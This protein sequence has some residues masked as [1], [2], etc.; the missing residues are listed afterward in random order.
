M[1]AF[2]ILI[3]WGIA[4]FSLSFLTHTLR[5]QL[6]PQAS[7]GRRHGK[8]S[9]IMSRSLMP[10]CSDS[11]FSAYQ[12]RVGRGCAVCA[13]CLYSSLKSR[14]GPP[15]PAESCGCRMWKGARCKQKSET[16]GCEM[17]TQTLAQ[18]HV[19]FCLIGT[20][21]RAVKALLDFLFVFLLC[22]QWTGKFLRCSGWAKMWTFFISGLASQTLGRVLEQIWWEGP[23]G[24]GA[25]QHLRT[26]V[27]SPG[28]MLKTATCKWIAWPLHMSCGR[29]PK[30][31]RKQN[32]SFQAR[33]REIQTSQEEQ[34][35]ISVWQESS[36][37]QPLGQTQKHTAMLLHLMWRAN[38]ARGDHRLRPT[39]KS[40][41]S[42][43]CQAIKGS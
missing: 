5:Q 33:R 17:G 8:G 4:F 18:I 21:F 20:P 25:C 11:C 19:L 28:L 29:D 12:W 39:H 36:S 37:T 7:S 27:W 31:R 13:S 32:C 1:W 41:Q 22:C 40:V 10:L 2:F 42:P 24:K 35:T 43:Q 38:R 15:R 3:S 26:N 23:V 14:K 34:N 30:W 6:F 9:A 16:S